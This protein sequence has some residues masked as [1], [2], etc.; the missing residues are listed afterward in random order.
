MNESMS[1]T[2][3]EARGCRYQLIVHHSASYWGNLLGIKM[4][5]IRWV[6]WF[7]ELIWG[8]FLLFLGSTGMHRMIT[9]SMVLMGSYLRLI[10]RHLKCSRRI[11]PS[12]L[13]M[14]FLMENSS[15]LIQA[16][17][18]SS[19]MV[20]MLL[21]ISVCFMLVRSWR[22]HLQMDL[23]SRDLA[24]L[25]LMVVHFLNDSSNAAISLSQSQNNQQNQASLSHQ[26]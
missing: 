10:L 25:L 26:E 18:K 17:S 9:T 23:P 16:V 22:I 13:G 15:M 21:M 14:Y 19:I 24:H 5:F 20:S 1:S 6:V 8:V 4:L 12:M 2:R 7:H 3:H 11:I